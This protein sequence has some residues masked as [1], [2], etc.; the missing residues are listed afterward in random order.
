VVDYVVHGRKFAQGAE[1]WTDRGCF[2][3]G[4]SVG[5]SEGPRVADAWG[6]VGGPCAEW[7]ARTRWGLWESSLAE[8]LHQLSSESRAALESQKGPSPASR[9]D[10]CKAIWALCP[11]CGTQEYGELTCLDRHFPDDV[12][13]QAEHVCEL[14][15]MWWDAVELLVRKQAESRGLNELSLKGPYLSEILRPYDDGRDAG[16]FEVEWK[17]QDVWKRCLDAHPAY[18]SADDQT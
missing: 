9:D 3:D 5:E 11:N 12:L 10:R 2:E 8:W 4:R 18:W 14:L 16:A 6:D 15:E 7:I 13:S 17:R 1:L